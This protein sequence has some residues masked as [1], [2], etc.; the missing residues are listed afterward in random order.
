[1]NNVLIMMVV[2]TI[3][4]NGLVGLLRLSINRARWNRIYTMLNK[5]C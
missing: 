4:T 1:M 5:M 2:T 3:A